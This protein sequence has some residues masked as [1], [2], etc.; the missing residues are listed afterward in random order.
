MKKNK[1]KLNRQSISNALFWLGILV[2]LFCVFNIGL[3]WYHNHQ[4]TAQAEKEIKLANEG[5]PSPA[6]ATIK[7]SADDIN[8]YTV[9]P[10]MPRFLRVDSLNVL[11]RVRQVGI[12]KTGA[13]GVPTN[14]Y[15]V[16]WYNKSSLPGA[17]GAAVI[18]GHVSSW[19]THGVFY[20][21]TSIK[22]NSIVQVEMGNGTLYN[23]KVVKKQVYSYDNVDMNALLSP[24]N[25]KLP[26]LNLI[27]C[28]GSVIKGTNEFNQRAIVFTQLVK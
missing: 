1:S 14:V 9:A 6:P 26:G 12:D 8:K 27:T 11:S 7:P 18:D 24:V 2:L 17:P 21:L 28:T 20:S 4:L 5:K 15:D 3:N 13:I 19:T 25:P 22:I 16:A 23:Y 10:G